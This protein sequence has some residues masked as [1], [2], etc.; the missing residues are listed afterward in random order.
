MGF[1]IQVG[2]GGR[3]VRVGVAEG[4]VGEADGGTVVAGAVCVTVAV[5]SSRS[6]VC[7]LDLSE[8][9]TQASKSSRQILP[10]NPIL[11]TASP[12]DKNL[13]HQMA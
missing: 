9:F 1:G 8:Q 4:K 5:L 13:D 6:G 12:Q 10:Y 7:G 2:V 3:D 11:N